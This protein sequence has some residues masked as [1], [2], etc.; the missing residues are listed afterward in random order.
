MSKYLIL[1]FIAANAFDKW[2][3]SIYGY[4]LEGATI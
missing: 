3:A 4:D 1:Q 2:N